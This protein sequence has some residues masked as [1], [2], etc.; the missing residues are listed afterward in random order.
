MIDQLVLLVCLVFFWVCRSC[1]HFFLKLKQRML[2]LYRPHLESA[3]VS[4]IIYG[5]DLE[6]I[7]HRFQ[8]SGRKRQNHLQ[9]RQNVRYSFCRH[10]IVIDQYH[11]ILKHLFKTYTL[12]QIWRCTILKKHLIQSN[13][14][15]WKQFLTKQLTERV[16]I[17]YVEKTNRQKRFT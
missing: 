4:N 14:I 16:L 8:S 5:E 10:A 7:T 15:Y 2:N 17:H 9:I 12:S 11:F 3:V 6:K 1:L 13:I